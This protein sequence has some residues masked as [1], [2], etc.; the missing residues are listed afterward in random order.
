MKIF[1]SSDHGGYELKNAIREY[2]AHHK[3]EVEDMGPSTL[4]PEDDYPQFA[5]RVVTALLGSEDAD[6]RGILVCRG[7]QGMAM[8]ANRVHG[9]R[10]AVAWN[11]KSAKETREDNNSNVLALAADHV[12]RQAAIKIVEAWLS[13]PFSNAPRHKRRL[14]EIEDI[15]G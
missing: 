1:L 4:N 6:P 2:L 3:Y 10:A 12:D 14:Q 11:E 8:A 9:I 5:Y 15:Y 13:Q 7:G